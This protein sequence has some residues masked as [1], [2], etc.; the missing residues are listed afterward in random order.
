MSKPLSWKVLLPIG[1]VVWGLG[2]YFSDSTIGS[3]G[4]LLGIIILL[5][6]LIDLGRQF[7]KKKK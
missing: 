2:K 1:L 4:A 6:G 3:A 5:I 7:F